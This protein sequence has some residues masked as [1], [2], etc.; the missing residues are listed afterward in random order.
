M[1]AYVFPFFDPHPGLHLYGQGSRAGVAIVLRGLIVLSKAPS[2]PLITYVAAFSLPLLA[3]FV[4]IA[5]RRRAGWIGSAAPLVCSIAGLMTLGLDY[6]GWQPDSS[7]FGRHDPWGFGFFAAGI[8]FLIAAVGSSAR[9]IRRQSGALPDAEV[10][11]S[12][13]PAA[14]ASQELLGRYRVSR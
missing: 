14:S 11:E 5:N 8:C 2:P 4:G 3:A 6:V 7:Y 10:R 9:L 1:I 12:F 13:E